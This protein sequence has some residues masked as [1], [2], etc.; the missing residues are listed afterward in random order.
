MKYNFTDENGSFILRDADKISYL[1]FP[2]A[3]PAGIMSAITPRLS[4][5]IKL[6]QNAFITPPESV[7]DLS[8][9]KSPRNFWLKFEDGTLRSASGLSVWQKAEGGHVTVNAGLLYHEVSTEITHKGAKLETNILS[10]VPAMNLKTEIMMVRLTNTGEES[11]SFTPVGVVELY[12]RSAANIRDHRHVTSLLSRTFT[13]D[14]GVRLKP[15]LSFD[16]RG[17]LKN[18]T[19]YF[20]LGTDGKGN[21]P[22]GFYTDTD[23]VTGEGGDLEMPLGMGPCKKAG[24]KS[25]GVESVGGIVFSKTELKAGESREYLLFIGADEKSEDIIN[26]LGSLKKAEKALEDTKSYWISGAE[27]TLNKMD[28]QKIYKD[29]FEKEGNISFSD[30]RAYMMWVATE[31]ELRRIFGCSFLPYHDYGKGGRGFRDL[32]QDCLALLLKDP[33]DVKDLLINNFAGIRSDGTNATIIGNKPGEFIA[34]RNGITRVWM[35]HGLWP[36]ITMDFYMELSGDADILSLEQTYFKDSQCMRARAVDKEFTG[37][38]NLLRTEKGGVYKGSLLEHLLLMHLTV[39]LDVGNNG[40]MLLRGADW[41]DALDMA[42]DKGESVAF[43]AAYAG[44]LKKLAFLIKEKYTSVHLM[45][46]LAELVE[47]IEGLFKTEVSVDDK[48]LVKA[49]RDLLNSYCE[50]VRN[51]VSGKKKEVEADRLAETLLA[52]SKD[53]SD[54]IRNKELLK[55]DKY[56]W[57]NGYYDNTGKQVESLEDGRLMLTGAVF[58]IMSGT[59]SDE[60]V[61]E[62]ANTA[63][64]FLFDE[65]VGGVRLNTRFANEEDYRTKLGRLFGFAYGTK[66]NGAV[67]CHMAVMYAYALLIRGFKDEALEVIK[68]LIKQSMDF[69]KSAIYPGIPEYFDPKGRGAYPYLTGAA[70]W[71]L[72]FMYKLGGRK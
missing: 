48:T 7:L 63:R 21:K 30:F 58:T 70:S 2:L 20:V 66:E 39:A 50:K 15:T 38:D 9:K 59:A 5:D 28:L 31:P 16:E 3:N 71:L 8:D 69:E 37:E 23:E 62:L 49:K 1:Y 25:E 27:K 68:L 57:Y 52:F 42:P 17:H 12:G 10:F 11:V 67:F 46:E 40:H 60:E 61:R 54:R 41:N 65:K 33:S 51:H 45:E 24:S 72:L 34:D 6:N 53:I 55:K 56:L 36:F 22:E 64:E 43:T 18:E 26:S 32:W 14:Y 13:E 4:G 35:D 44:N 47:D 29:F 19:E